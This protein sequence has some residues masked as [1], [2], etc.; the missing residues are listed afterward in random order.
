M[1]RRH[2]KDGAINKIRAKTMNI[3]VVVKTV[4]GTLII[5]WPTECAKSK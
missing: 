1:R 5:D 2:N 4:D 3:D